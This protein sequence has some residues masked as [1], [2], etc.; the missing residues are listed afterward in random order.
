M[1]C[2][3]HW[4]RRGDYHRRHIRIGRIPGRGY[5]IYAIKIRGIRRI[6]R[7]VSRRRVRPRCIQ[8][9]P[10]ASL[11]RPSFHREASLV[12]SIVIPRQADIRAI[13]NRR[14]MRRRRGPGP[15]K[16]EPV[17]IRPRPARAAVIKRHLHH[18]LPRRQVKTCPRLCLP[19]LIAARSRNGDR[20]ADNGVVH[21][22]V[23]CSRGRLHRRRTHVQLISPRRRNIHGVQQIL[24]RLH[25]R[26]IVVAG[27]V[28]SGF[29]IDALVRPIGITQVRDRRVRIRDPLPA[30]VE[31]FRLNLLRHV[32][33]RAVIRR[34]P[35]ARTPPPPT[36]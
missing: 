18:M 16:L 11:T 2:K 35:A 36:R 31:I 4:L 5:R 22:D 23:K 19:R 25:V 6:R 28:G 24:A 30:V 27:C 26:H 14:Q 9:R 1:A 20:C 34:T 3:I 33:R 8:H 21:L 15:Y 7:I 17:Q 13:G 32:H 10:R 12:A 29:N